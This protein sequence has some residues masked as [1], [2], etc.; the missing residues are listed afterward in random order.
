MSDQ[1]RYTKAVE[2]VEQLTGRSVPKGGLKELPFKFSNEF[3]RNFDD[4]MAYV[5]I[6]LE[7]DEEAWDEVGGAILEFVVYHVSAECRRKEKE[8]VNNFVL[9]SKEPTAKN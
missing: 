6:H 2:M 5:N 9:Y 4:L 8:A 1:P 3:S 7:E